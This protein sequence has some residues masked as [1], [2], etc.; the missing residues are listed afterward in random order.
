MDQA[1]SLKFL[2][3][4]I[5]LFQAILAT[6]GIRA[7]VLFIYGDIQ[8]TNGRVTIGFSAGDRVRYF[9]LPESSSSMT[10]LDLEKTSNCVRQGVYVYRVDESQFVRAETCK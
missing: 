3:A 5:N 1:P 10:I 4:Q 7:Y 9:A 8:W 6:D 2:L